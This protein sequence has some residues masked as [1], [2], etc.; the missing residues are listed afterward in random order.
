MRADRQVVDPVEV[1]PQRRFEPR[2][3]AASLAGDEDAA[4]PKRQARP[5]DL[6]AEVPLPRSGEEHRRIGGVHHQ[7]VD[8]DVRE[9]VADRNP[10]RAGVD[11]FEDAARNSSRIEQGGIDRIDDDHA[12]PPADV[13]R[14]E[15]FP[16]RRKRRLRCLPPL[17]R[18][19]DGRHRLASLPGALVRRARID[20]SRSA[21]P[22]RA[23]VL[24]GRV[25]SVEPRLIGLC[26]LARDGRRH[27]GRRRRPSAGAREHGGSEK[28]NQAHRRIRG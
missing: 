11:R 17:G 16:P 6:L 8:G 20:V 4:A 7:R 21:Q 27:R 12:R 23:R 5:A 13:S 28:R 25:R 10:A 14:A 18:E 15:R 24:L 26:D 9:L 19:R 22:L 2:P 3:G 1:L